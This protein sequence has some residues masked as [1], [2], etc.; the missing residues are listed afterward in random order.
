[1]KPSENPRNP[2]NQPFNI[3]PKPSKKVGWWYPKAPNYWKR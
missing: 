3:T 2:A 1:M